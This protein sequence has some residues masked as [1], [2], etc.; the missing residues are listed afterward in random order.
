MRMLKNKAPFIAPIFH[1]CFS[2]AYSPSHSL[3]NYI[4]IS[5]G[6]IPMTKQHTTKSTAPPIMSA[7]R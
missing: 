3:K 6:R 1:P 4:L 7:D 5:R 2:H